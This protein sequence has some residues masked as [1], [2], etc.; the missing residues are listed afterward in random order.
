MCFCG[1]C[2]PQKIHG[3]PFCGSC[4]FRGSHKP[5]KPHDGG[6]RGLC[7]PPKTH[8]GPFCGLCVFIGFT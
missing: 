8:G 1:L 5:Q 7:A 3:G 6:K 2:K 4:V